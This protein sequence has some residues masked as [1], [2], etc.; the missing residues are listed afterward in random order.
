MEERKK[1]LENLLLD[2]DILNELDKWINDINFFEISGM[3]NQE[4]KHSKT[5]SWFLD[6]NENHSLNDQFIRRLIQKIINKN[7]N[8]VKGLDAFDFS[9]IDYSSFVVKRE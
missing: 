9:L 4:I 8:V 5:L 7:I 2:I 6:P 3:T 1:I